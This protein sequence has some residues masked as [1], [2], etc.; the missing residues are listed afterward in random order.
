MRQSPGSAGKNVPK[1]VAPREDRIG[2]SSRSLTPLYSAQASRTPGV[3]N[4]D[5][6]NI[7]PLYTTAGTLRVDKH[8]QK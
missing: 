1:L 3:R 7:G 4:S 6:I 5:R 8:A 2:D